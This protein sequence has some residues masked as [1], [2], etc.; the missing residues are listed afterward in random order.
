MLIERQTM[1]IL[2]SCCEIK[3]MS[4]HNEHKIETK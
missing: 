4:N 1:K 3:N 2:I